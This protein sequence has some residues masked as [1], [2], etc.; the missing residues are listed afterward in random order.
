LADL[1]AVR[2]TQAVRTPADVAWARR[3]MDFTAFDYADVLGP[4]FTAKNLPITA[5]FLW[6]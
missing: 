5:E 6:R 2:G 1:E 3:I 4:W